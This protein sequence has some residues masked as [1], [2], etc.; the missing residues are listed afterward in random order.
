MDLDE[1]ILNTSEIR[2]NTMDTTMNSNSTKVK[3]Y[4]FI[5]SLSNLQ[6]CIFAFFFIQLHIVYK[7]SIKS[8]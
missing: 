2:P 4:R 3:V 8:I 5:E 6:V 1:K 7:Y